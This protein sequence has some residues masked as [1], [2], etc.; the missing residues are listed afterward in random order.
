MTTTPEQDAPETET[1]EHARQGPARAKV[2]TDSYVSSHRLGLATREGTVFSE[3]SLS[4]DQGALGVI[5]GPSG[6]GR[7]SLLLA[8]A[9]RMRGLTGSLTVAGIDGIREAKRLRQIT[10]IA[11]IGS[12][13]DIEGQLTVGD[14]LVERALIDGIKPDRAEQIFGHATT[15]LDC[16]LPRHDLVDE[17]GALQR[18]QLSVALASLRPAHLLLLDDAERGLSRADQA[19][20]LASLQRL[21]DTGVTLIISSV[22]D[23][24]APAQTFSLVDPQS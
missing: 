3:V 2:E 7:S 20:L 8:L 19:E 21:T 11:R 13:I 17:L 22:E 23:H 9:G 24:P 18:T 15:I 5:Q 10:S 1:P 14:S 6:S 12:L 4:F 16:D